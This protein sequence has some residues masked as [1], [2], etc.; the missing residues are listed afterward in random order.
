M[1]MSNGLGSLVQSNTFRVFCEG[2]L[3]PTTLWSVREVPEV[4]CSNEESSRGCGADGEVTVVPESVVKVPTG[5][6]SCKIY[7]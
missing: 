1:D 5:S 7:P 4:T 3:G 2:C 6:T